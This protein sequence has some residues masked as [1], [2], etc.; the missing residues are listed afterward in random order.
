MPSLF[1]GMPW[2]KI[3]YR[4][5]WRPSSGLLA[6]APLS[7]SISRFVILVDWL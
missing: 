3:V 7:S 6:D 5:S 4:N 2:V 1:A